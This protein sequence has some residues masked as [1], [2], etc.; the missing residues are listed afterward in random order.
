VRVYLGCEIIQDR[1]QGTVECRQSI[2]AQRMLNLYQMQECNPAA[3]PLSPGSRLSKVDSPE[4][5]DPAL[6]RL[7]R[8]IVGHIGY[9]VSMTRCDLS[10]AYAE[11]SK[12]VAYPG[13]VHL[14]AAKHALSYIRG[15]YDKGIKFFRDINDLTLR[16]I[17]VGWVDS[18]FAADP[19]TRKSVTGYVL[20]LNGGPVS[21]KS[22]RQDCVTLSSAEAEYVAASM[23][24][25]EVVYVRALLDSFGHPQR[26][27]TYIWEDNQ[28]CIHMSEN[29]KHRKYSRHIDT[30][31]YYCRDQVRDGILKLKKCA[32]TMNVADANTKSLPSPAFNKHREYMW[33]TR[34]PFQAFESGVIPTGREMALEE[35][36][37]NFDKLFI[38]TKS[39]SRAI[40]G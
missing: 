24:G 19:D 3:T 14:A 20:S 16:N 22:K 37:L 31:R 28:S 13:T 35:I 8:G 2:Y 30:R 34:L 26:K 1:Q 10:F 11:L 23:C 39:K 5:I 9:L 4:Y 17:L 36:I 12:F 15:T 18:D 38:G 7:Y 40:G 29:P 21:W 32:G 33:G 27:P 25:Q 6:Q